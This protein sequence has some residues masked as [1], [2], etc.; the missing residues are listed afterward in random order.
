MLTVAVVVI[1]LVEGEVAISL[2]LPVGVTSVVDVVISFISVL[3]LAD[4]VVD[5]FSV[6]PD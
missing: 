1:V 4:R 2:V 5:M 3:V 6:E